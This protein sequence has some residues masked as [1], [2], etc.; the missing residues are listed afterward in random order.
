[1]PVPVT[2]FEQMDDSDELDPEMT[3]PVPEPMIVVPYDPDIVVKEEIEEAELEP[4][5]VSQDERG[6][7]PPLHELSQGN[8][9]AASAT[10]ADPDHDD[11]FTKKELVAAQ[12]AEEAI[13][14]AIE[15]FKKGEPPDRDEIR[16]VLEEAKQ[17]LLQFETLTVRDGLLYR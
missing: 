12:Q 5:L 15:F 14:V 1:V 8:A 13:R 16:T 4:E 11:V 7:P 6:Q 17:L 10:S 9:M 2:Q 3:N